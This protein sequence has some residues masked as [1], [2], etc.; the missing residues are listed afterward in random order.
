M[1]RRTLLKVGCG[2]VA[3]L[4]ST[5][6]FAGNITIEDQ[7]AGSK[8]FSGGPLGQGNEDNST[9][10]GSYSSQAWDYEAMIADA[11]SGQWQVGVI[12]GFDMK[13]GVAPANSITYTAPQ[14]DIFIRVN[15]VVDAH[16]VGSSSDP[17]DF[18]YVIHFPAVPP[19]PGKPY[20]TAGYW[21]AG[22]DTISY[23]VYSASQVNVLPTG[24][25]GIEPP[26]SLLSGWLWQADPLSGQTPLY[27]GFA[28]YADNLNDAGVSSATGV[29]VVGGNHDVLS[30]L[31]IDRSKLTLLTDSSSLYFFTTM[32]CGNDLLEGKLNVPDSG[33]TLALLG[34]GIGSLALV[35]RRLRR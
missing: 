30:G 3:A 15:N 7:Y 21:T 22:T 17:I 16:T 32:G 5:V 4:A 10:P 1:N 8:G 34:I 31:L 27:S 26:T 23:E 12:A 35:N 25:G 28:D 11:T 20:G 29:S 6:V 33:A 19:P 9:E 24:S 2:G 18:D 14:G 13:S